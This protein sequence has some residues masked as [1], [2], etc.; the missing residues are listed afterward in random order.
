MQKEII[1]YTTDLC[2]YCIK[3]KELFNSQKMQ[4][5]EILASD[6]QTRNEML[7]KSNG[8]KTVPQIFIG[9]EHIGGF[10]EL[11]RLYKEY[12]LEKLVN[13]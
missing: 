13:C 1:I 4:Y 7:N 3:A 6:E 5:K 9:N 12:K 8:R 11:Y 10:D 2:P